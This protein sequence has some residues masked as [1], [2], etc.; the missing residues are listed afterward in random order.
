MQWQSCSS[1]ISRRSPRQPFICAYQHVH[2]SILGGDDDDD[3][4]KEED[5]AHGFF[6]L[7]CL[8]K[9]IKGR[10]WPMSATMHTHPD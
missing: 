1:G 5:H 3:N 2:I 10:I 7:H 8:T 9:D 6:L 4:D